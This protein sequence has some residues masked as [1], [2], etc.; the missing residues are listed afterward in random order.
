MTDFEDKCR[1]NAKA[2]A[3]RGPW[4]K[5]KSAVERL[6]AYFEASTSN[7]VWRDS[8]LRV[9]FTEGLS[10]LPRKQNVQAGLAGG[11]FETYEQESSFG[12]SPSEDMSVII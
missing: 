8:A 6:G 4:L 5:N 12:Q 3:N 9:A 1:L 7:I 10:S 11:F 2:P